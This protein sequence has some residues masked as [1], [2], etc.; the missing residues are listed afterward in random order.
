M[1][2]AMGLLLT[3]CLSVG[4]LG[5]CAGNSQPAGTPVP[6]SA[7]AE[8]T[9]TAPAAAGEPVTIKFYTW[10]ASLKDQ[11]DAVVK[12]FEDKYPN[13]KVDI[14]YPV[15]NDNVEYTKKIDMLLLTNEQIDCMMESSVAKMTSKVDRELYQPLDSF[16][17][18]EGVNYD[19]IYSVSSNIRGSYYGLPIDISP[20]FVMINKTMLDAAKLPVPPLDW[21]W[22]DYRDYAIKLT[23]G[24]GQD[25][26]Y[27][28]YF[29]NWN[30]Y[31][32]MGMY[33]TK[34]DNCFYK[35][36]GSLNF[37]DPNLSGWLQFRYGLENQ[38]KAS[39]PLMDVKT[40]KLAYRN[41]YFG[42]KVA[43][44]PTGAWML[45]EIKD[46][47]KWPHDFQTVFAPLPKWKD[48][49]AGRTFSDTKMLSIPASA[50]YPE[51]AYQFI[52]FYTTE[53]AH[54]RAGGLTA[55]KNVDVKNT[56]ATIIGPNPDALYNTDSL[57]AVFNNPALQ[58]N[59]PLMAPPYDAE[60]GTMF[61]EE[62]DKYMVGGQTL[63]ECINALK[64]R[65]A[66]I[67]A[68]SGK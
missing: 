35:E 52:R 68:K 58:Y 65:G 7:G 28:S 4:I 57:Y 10:E 21:T 14:Q 42:G 34:M 13:I 63:D 30:N 51:Q 15:E 3:A 59:A 56:I 16:F 33:S 5:G 38:D 43:M 64:T 67:V 2:K 54:I 41:E 9:A 32:Q 18:A 48:G 8:S 6:A 39:V 40:S 61:G 62:C 37:D 45:A 11:N 26:V 17:A 12:A 47:V 25:K 66:D 36:D 20:W 31:Y 55:E 53:G 22:D 27:G 23:H 19:D 46:T 1:K 29:H 44:L 60:I 49:A 24:E 50:K